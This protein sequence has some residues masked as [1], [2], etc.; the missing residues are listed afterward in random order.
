MNSLR[1]FKHLPLSAAVTFVLSSPAWGAAPPEAIN[2]CSGQTAGSSCSFQSPDGQTVSGSCIMVEA[3][4]ACAPGGTTQPPP[5]G[6]DT[7]TPPDSGTGTQSGSDTSGSVDYAYFDSASGTLFLPETNAGS[8]GTYYVTL[9]LTDSNPI[10]FDLNSGSLVPVTATAQPDA[11]Y[12]PATG[13]LSIP[14]VLVGTNWLS[15]QLTQVPAFGVFRFQLDSTGQGQAPDSTGTTG[16]STGTGSNTNGATDITNM[17]LTNLSA[18]CSDYVA[19]LTSS[20]TDINNNKIFTGNVE[21]SVSGDKCRISSNAIPNHDFHDGSTRFATDVAEQSQAFEIPA[22]PAAAANVT[23]LSLGTDNAVM[24]NGVKVDLLAAACYGVG[25]G[26][27]GCND[28]NQP[29][30]FDPMFSNNDFGTDSHNAHTQPDGT[31]HYHG[32]PNALFS[33]TDSS[34]ASPV[35]GFA[36]DGFPIYG[37]YFND[38]GTIRK[39]NPSYRVKS[40][41]RPSGDGNPGGTYDGTYRDDYEYVAGLGDLDECNGMTVNGVYAYYVTESFPYILACLKGTPDSSFSKL[42]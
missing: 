42:P 41:T 19:T 36:A 32:S 13:V 16:D 29:W 4:L 26:K 21:I 30:R 6:T 7:T 10:T 9:G 8:L 14:T 35:V 38:N 31:Y 40:G 15:A 11:T 1:I 3:D 20:V 12:D 33:S 28:S 2:A 5:S 25:D 37:S 24:L 22:S 34:Q 23:A 18:N 39:A 27:V 17:I